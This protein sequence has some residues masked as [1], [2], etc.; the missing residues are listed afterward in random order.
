MKRRRRSR[1]H[2]LLFFWWRSYFVCGCSGALVTVTAK[3][4][5]GG[6]QILCVVVLVF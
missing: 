4:R 2:S 3:K 5:D 6:F 1:R